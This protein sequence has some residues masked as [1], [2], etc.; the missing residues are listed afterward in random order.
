M[1]H[2]QE[3]FLH[4]FHLKAAVTLLSAKLE[5]MNTWPQLVFHLFFI[6]FFIAWCIT[7]FVCLFV[8][9]SV[10]AYINKCV[11]FSFLFTDNLRE[12]QWML[13]VF[14]SNN[15]KM[16]IAKLFKNNKK[17]YAVMSFLGSYKTSNAQGQVNRA[18]KR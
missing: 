17:Q 3:Y 18:M 11:S 4:Y 16:R 8:F 15:Y 7:G 13:F 12:V 5:L 14:F 10:S 2:F 6:Y 1:A 9:V